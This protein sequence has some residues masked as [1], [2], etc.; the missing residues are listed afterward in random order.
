MIKILSEK[1]LENIKRYKYGREGEIKCFIE[2]KGHFKVKLK[3]S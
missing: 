3:N 1:Q 2:D